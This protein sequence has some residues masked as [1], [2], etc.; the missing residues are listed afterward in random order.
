MPGR[1]VKRFVQNRHP[2]MR[3]F[4]AIDLAV[5]IVPIAVLFVWCFASTWTY[6]NILPDE[7]GL[8]GIQT[9]ASMNKDLLQTV[10]FSIALSLTVSVIATVLSFF[11]A[12]ALALYDFK[13]KYI[14]DFLVLLPLCI[15]ATALAMGIHVYLLRAGLANSVLGVILVH[16]IIVMPYSVKLLTDPLRIMGRK[17]SEQAKNLG[18]GSVRAF[19]S[20]ELAP[21]LP[22]IMASISLTFIVS[23]GQYFLTFII[24]GGRVTTLA[25]LMAPW[26]SA[27]DRSV[28]AVY[29]AIYLISTLAVFLVL[30]VIE[31]ALSKRRR[32]YLV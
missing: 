29:A 1:K 9:V 25:L 16:L 20:V 19:F 2:F 28:A 12:R 14:I 21:L 11:A 30:D 5:V 23:F 15:S 27:A 13:G 18:A 26:I 7:W 6:P 10:A 32:N 8:T 24:G 3:L 4:I 22:S 17:L 31:K